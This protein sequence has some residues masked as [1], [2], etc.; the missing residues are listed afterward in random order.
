MK[1]M[2]K[3]AGLIVS[4]PHCGGENTIYASNLCENEFVCSWTHC[5]KEFATCGEDDFH[6]Y[7]EDGKQ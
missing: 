2:A 7:I 4:C 6:R 3:P 5:E 1:K